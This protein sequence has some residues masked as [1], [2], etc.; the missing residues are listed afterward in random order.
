MVG[1]NTLSQKMHATLAISVIVLWEG[2]GFIPYVKFDLYRNSV[3]VFIYW[4]ILISYY[5]KYQ[6][7]YTL[8]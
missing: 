7:R 4:F 2:L 6:E 5:K 8:R 1:F 3:F